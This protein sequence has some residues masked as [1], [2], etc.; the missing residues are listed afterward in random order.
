V[1]FL[2]RVR[3]SLPYVNIGTTQLLN[4]LIFTFAKE[5]VFSP[6]SL[7]S[8]VNSIPEKLVMK[9]FTKC[10]ETVGHNPGTNQFDFGGNR[11]LDS[12]RGIP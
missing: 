1:F 3:N 7:C 6:V 4:S 9:S 2:V 8:S 12:D 11:N 5:V 10:Y